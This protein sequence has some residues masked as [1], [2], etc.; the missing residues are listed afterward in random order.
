MIN[1]KILVVDRVHYYMINELK[2]SNFIVDYFEN[3][4]R[5][6]IIDKIRNYHGLIIRSKT[7][8]DKELLQHAQKLEFIGRVGAGLENIDLSF[9]KS[10]NIN[11]IN[12]PEGNRDAVAEHTVGMILNLFNNL[13]KANT[14]V[15]NGIWLREENRGYELMGKTVG[16]IGYGNMGSAFAKRLK[17]FNVNTISYDKYKKNYQDEYT[18]EVD[19]QQIFEQTDILSL[20]VPLTDE[21]KNMFNYSFINQFKK[22]F[23]LINTARGKVV[24]T[25]HLVKNLKIGKILGAALDV[26]EY[27]GKKY[28]NIFNQD[29]S[30]EIKYIRNSNKV[31]MSPH[32]AGWTFESN[33]KLAKVLV[34][35]ILDFYELKI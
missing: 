26:F 6:D 22:N 11:C 7:P 18:T 34:D 28:Q 25:N 12:V 35:K 29:I 14:E 32:V 2:K 10:L 5:K 8:V 24:N 4:N 1:K 15:K 19:L 13:S 23:Y 20:H 3:I 30:E 17:G 9:A 21:T 33:Y 31:L 16:I 27:E